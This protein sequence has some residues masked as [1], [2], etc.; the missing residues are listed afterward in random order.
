MFRHAGDANEAFK[1]LPGAQDSDSLGRAQKL[2][3]F[4]AGKR[5][6][7]SHRS[8][9]GLD[10]HSQTLG[11]SMFVSSCLQFALQ[12]YAVPQVLV[13]VLVSGAFLAA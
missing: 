13:R 9:G 12:L 5:N 1:Q 10:P 6:V 4:T 3:K 2:L 7:Q 8:R 11:L